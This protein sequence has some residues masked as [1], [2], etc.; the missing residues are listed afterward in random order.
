M[1]R[2]LFCIGIGFWVLVLLNRSYAAWAEPAAPQLGGASLSIYGDTL[3]PGWEDW[4]WDSAV[5]GA[6]AGERHQ[7]N[8]AYAVTYQT[9]WASF[10]LHRGAAVDVSEFTHLRFW[11]HGGETGGQKIE[12][13]LN[14]SEA[15]VFSVTATA[16]EWQQVDV[17]LAQMG[18]FV[19]VS[20]IYW[21]DATGGA[22]ATF[23]IDDIEFTDGEGEVATPTPTP[24]GPQ[25]GE[26]DVTLAID[27]AAPRKPISEL[28]YGMHYVADEPFAQEIAL[29]IRRWGGNDKTRYNWQIGATNHAMD[30]FFHNNETYDPITFTSMDAD[31]WVQ[32]NKRTN[33]AS[34]LTLPMTG[35]VAKDG[36]P[37][38]CS[39]LA[40]KYAGQD[41]VDDESGFPNC[42]NGLQ[43]GLPVLADPL[44]TSLAI[45][46][47]F[48]QQWL[49]HLQEQAAQNG[50]VKFFN[51]DNEPDIW[52]ETHRDIYPTAWKYA[53]F[54]D[55]TYR[56]AAAV[57]ATAPNV[58]LLGPVVNG[59]TY[60]WHGSW[61]GQREDWD[62]PDD[63]NAHGGTPF[64]AWYLQQMKLYE[65]QN[66]V[67]LLD[68]FDLHYY[69]Q[70]RTNEPG[71]SLSPAGDAATQAR[72]LRST[73][74]LWDPTYAD[75]SWIPE[76]GPEEGIIQ[77]IPRMRSWVDQNYPGTKLA[78][79]EYNWGGLE[80]INGALAQADVLGIFGR[81]GLDLATFF[82]PGQ[83]DPLR[84]TFPSSPAA[85][86]FRIYR[87]YDG[88][89]SR[90]GD[91]SVNASSSDQARLAVYAAERTSDGAITLVVINKAAESLTGR[92]NLLN[93]A[94]RQSLK[95]A[96]AQRYQYS[97]AQL[98]AIVAQPDIALDATG[99]SA[100]FAANS[101][102]L[103]VIDA[104]A[105]LPTPGES[106]T[107][108]PT[109]V[110]GQ[111]PVPGATPGPKA[112]DL[113]LP[114]AKSG[115]GN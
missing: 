26:A 4:S 112:V 67:R 69:P 70:S 82:D 51:L 33:T 58:A 43:N 48:V 75:E 86:A 91:S 73:R 103:I 16:N 63:R 80:H 18:A 113:F 105:P 97:A 13:K 61:D 65:E 54:R 49:I 88:Q 39:F 7:G 115:A 102:S 55:L 29:P 21:Q 99:F 37:N 90:F 6:F 81:E 38:S 46:E 14:G 79:T 89:G 57:K 78:I 41:D 3:Q 72:R 24:A 11:I 27:L 85:F 104:D 66:G 64:V 10:A 15:Q 30:W 23:Y 114:I 56:Y 68:Y 52:F 101:I 31:Q 32:R 28:I 19:T 47:Q 53:E 45:D 71:I 109:P 1:I 25:P 40:N 76:A 74:S 92:V 110:A 42:G 8:V 22:Q 35:Y 87:N 94:N 50:E 96:N 95:A 111:T 17:A 93:G 108:T 36:D 83:S 34:I 9:A 106:P 77:L 107:P 84:T 5:D 2:K 98:D 44:D 60:Y 59:W 100:D 62:S 20:D 12:V